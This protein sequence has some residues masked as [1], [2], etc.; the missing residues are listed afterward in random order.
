MV[1]SVSL[2][3]NLREILGQLEEEDLHVF[4]KALKRTLPEAPSGIDKRSF[5]KEILVKEFSK[6]EEGSLKELTLFPTEKDLW[7]PSIPTFKN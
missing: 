3:D 7:A 5:W 1:G 2:A 4:F 6:T